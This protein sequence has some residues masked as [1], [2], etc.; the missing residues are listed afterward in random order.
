M[1]LIF[2]TV[3]RIDG[4]ILLLKIFTNP[5]RERVVMKLVLTR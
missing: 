4:Q 5:I 3:N 2:V 1:I